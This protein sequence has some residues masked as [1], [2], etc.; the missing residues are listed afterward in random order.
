MLLETRRR[1]L[2]LLLPAFSNIHVSMYYTN[3]INK[4]KIIT[5][6]S[7]IS[8]IFLWFLK[9]FF[10]NQDEFKTDIVTVNPLKIDFI[11]FAD[12]VI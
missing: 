7:D 4:H 2:F 8:I 11:V 10:Q 12:L 3:S 6:P 5:Y 9:V 1:S